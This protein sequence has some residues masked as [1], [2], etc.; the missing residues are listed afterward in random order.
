M[1]LITILLLLSIQYISAQSVIDQ[2]DDN[3]SQAIAKLDLPTEK[4]EKVGVSGT[5]FIISNSSSSFNKGDFI[6]LVF[7]NNLVNRAIV[8]KVEG[9]SAGIKIVKVYSNQY[10]KILS[11]G[12]A[13]KIIRGDDTFF[14]NLK[15]EKVDKKS[16]IDDEDDLFNDTTLLSDDIDLEENTKRLIRTD[17]LAF[18]MGSSLS[19]V[20]VSGA[21]KR[22]NQLGASFAYQF[23][24][25][26]WL[27]GS[28]NINNLTNYPRANENVSLNNIIFRAKY[29]I[30]MPGFS[31]LQ[32]YIG[33]QIIT[34]SS[35]ISNPTDDE[36]IQLDRL[37]KNQVVFGASVLKRLVPGWF[38][39]GDLG[40][41]LI[42]LGLGIEF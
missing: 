41:D 4:I 28:Y 13:V 7:D 34:A 14:A 18:A 22:Y 3:R 20:D 6:S 39:R 1:K 36:A 24:D 17:W 16:L 33:F 29:T 9:S 15:N 27:E 26:A 23:K 10:H 8:A 19:S 32:P 40:T 38:V 21:V 37:P 25:N 2:I 31:Y 30:A 5:V 35:S 12:R 11:P 42:A